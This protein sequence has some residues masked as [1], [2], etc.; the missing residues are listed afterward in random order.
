MYSRWF[1]LHC[2]FLFQQLNLSYSVDTQDRNSESACSSVTWGEAREWRFSWRW[3][4][5][6]DSSRTWRSA[7]HWWQFEIVEWLTS[8]TTD[9]VLD[10]ILFFRLEGTLGEPLSTNVI[11]TADCVIVGLHNFFVSRYVAIN[12]PPGHFSSFGG[13]ARGALTSLVLWKDKADIFDLF[14]TLY[15]F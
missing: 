3:L 5:C 14:S 2:S 7:Q 13:T 1:G 15:I 6:N 8:I 9:R 10:V 4:I 12:T 11:Q